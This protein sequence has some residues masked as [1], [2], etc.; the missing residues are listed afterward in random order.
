M[1]PAETFCRASGLQVEHA[2]TASAPRAV[3]GALLCDAAD[4]ANVAAAVDT[5]AG[6]PGDNGALGG[7]GAPGAGGVGTL[8]GDDVRV[9]RGDG[10]GATA[11]TP[12]QLREWQRHSQRTLRTSLTAAR[13]AWSSF[14]AASEA[15][16]APLSELSDA[17]LLLV[18]L[19]VCR[20]CVAMLRRPVCVPRHLQPHPRLCRCIVYFGALSPPSLQSSR[21]CSGQYGLL[22]LHI[23]GI[24]YCIHRVYRIQQLAP[25]Y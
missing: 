22:H 13:A 24:I 15:G 8:V 10:A 25:V 2:M 19:K 6:A 7:A 18:R 3:F 17:L 20:L 9:P 14:Q 11:P 5:A 4:K 23:F 12:A 16:R 1:L 21:L